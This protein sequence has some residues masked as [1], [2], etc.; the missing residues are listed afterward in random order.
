MSRLSE[1]RRRQFVGHSVLGFRVQGSVGE[2]AVGSEA[3][4][5]EG[6]FQGRHTEL[7]SIFEPQIYATL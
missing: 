5:I 2:R 3:E 4:N 7:S 1:I 6:S